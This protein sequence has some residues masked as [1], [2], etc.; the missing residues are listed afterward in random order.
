MAEK[1]SSKAVE[2]WR[3]P[4]V[5]EVVGEG[6][7]TWGGGKW[8]NAEVREALVVLV[9]AGKGLRRALGQLSQDYG[10]MP[11]MWLVGK[12]LRELPD[13]KDAYEGALEIRGQVIAE[14]ALDEVMAA[15]DKESAAVAKVR[16]DHMRWMASKFSRRFTDRKVIEEE[17]THK[18]SD[19]ELDNRIKALMADPDLAAVVRGTLSETV[20]DAEILEEDEAD[21]SDSQ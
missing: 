20:Q 18:L 7:R 11:S 17:I 2:V 3:P 9:A 14:D 12:W 4:I 6:V 8:N 21:E 15:N 13:F 5:A 19:S 10:Q 1:K 16:A